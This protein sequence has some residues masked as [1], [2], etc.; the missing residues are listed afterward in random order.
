MAFQFSLASVLRFRESVEKREEL[1]LQRVQLEIARVYRSID[2]LTGDLIDALD[3]RDRAL[4]TP[5][6]AL[7][8]QGMQEKMTEAIQAKQNLSASLHILKNERERQMRLYQAAHRS[9]E[10]LTDLSTQ[11]RNTW[12][13]RQLRAQQKSLDDI[14]A[15]RAQRE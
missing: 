3:K 6:P 12:E 14:F 1:A 9:R 15:A 11:Q 10:I 2:K 7:Y 8:L 13:Q 4:Q 5:T